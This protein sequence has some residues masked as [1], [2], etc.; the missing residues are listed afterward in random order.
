MRK[1]EGKE[2][3]ETSG[4]LGERAIPRSRALPAD[5]ANRTRLWNHYCICG[6]TQGTG[7]G[8]DNYGGIRRR[9]AGAPT[10]IR[11]GLQCV[12]MDPRRFPACPRGLFF[13]SKTAVRGA[14]FTPLAKHIQA[15]RTRAFQ[16]PPP[17]L[18]SL[19]ASQPLNLHATC[20]RARSRPRKARN[21]IVGIKRTG[22]G[23]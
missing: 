8:M 9:I 21:G 13:S 1:K 12:D 18:P 7:A 6:L 23:L 11:C 20:C 14:R 2:K 16:K 3:C 10:I 17:R 19:E 22:T 4:N 5:T 15:R